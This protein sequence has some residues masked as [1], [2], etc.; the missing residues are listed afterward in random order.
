M[1]AVVVLVVVASALVAADRLAAP[2]YEFEIER[3]SSATSYPV[4]EHLRR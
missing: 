3:S 4:V 2:H 1:F